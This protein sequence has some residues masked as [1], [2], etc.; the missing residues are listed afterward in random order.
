MPHCPLQL[1][2]CTDEMADCLAALGIYITQS[3]AIQHGNC[4]LRALA[5]PSTSRGLP[6][7]KLS[8]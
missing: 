4:G 6:P 5:N 7:I 1:M 8:R 2:A 3:I